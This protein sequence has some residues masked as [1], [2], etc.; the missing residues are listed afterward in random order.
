[1][2]ESHTVAFAER[3]EYDPELPL[4]IVREAV[5]EQF[6]QFGLRSVEHLGSGCAYD[7]Y[8]VD[9]A[10]VFKFPR[11]AEAA[12]DL[13][14]IDRIQ[15]LVA[16]AVGTDF[17]IPRITL[18]ATPSARFPHRF[19]GHPLIRGAQA[20]DVRETPELADDLGRALARIHSI[21]V[22]AGRGLDLPLAEDH[23]R[24]AL[25]EVRQEVSAVPEIEKIASIECEWLKRLSATPN[26]WPSV[27]RVIHGDLVPRHI[28][29]SE[30]TGRLSGI[31]D[32][33][34]VLGDPA[35]DFSY[36]LFCR[37]LSFLRRT[38]DA[39]ELEVDP[40]FVERTVFFARLHALGW[41]ACAIRSSW[42][43]APQL[44]ILRSTFA[45]D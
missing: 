4:D 12:H 24:T 11:H 27:P 34:P 31:I 18:W 14:R 3:Q 2:D 32:W 35:Q 19:V 30:T 9:D 29:V 8:A 23:C 13:D 33:S 37:S 44:G 45:S 28:I 26:D 5:R 43:T 38:L 1:M 15:N 25:D 6:P 16:S 10:M 20:W 42:D 17:G 39:Y 36:L 21:P 40:A 22:S 41:L 7:A